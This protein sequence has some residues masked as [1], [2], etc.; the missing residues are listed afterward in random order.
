MD[1][2][3]RV[4]T[5]RDVERLASAFT[6]YNK[7]REQYE[8]YFQENQ[9]GERLTLI[10][11]AGDE[12]VGYGNIRWRAEY[13]PFRQSEIPEIVDLNVVEEFRRRGIA[14]ALILEAERI[15]AERSKPVMGIGVGVTP[16]Y[17]AA[18]RLYPKL[19]YAYDGRGPRHTPYGDILYLTKTLS[20]SRGR[21]LE[22]S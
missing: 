20:D 2:T 19:G 16:D 9:R 4:M 1:F 18:R 12:V 11:F 3:I 10:A 15:A 5:E 7:S 6:R 21:G 22:D 14:T 17:D 8:R 13:E